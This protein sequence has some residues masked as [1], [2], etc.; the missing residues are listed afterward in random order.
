M[1]G[2]ASFLLSDFSTETLMRD[3]MK[4]KIRVE[5]GRYLFY[6]FTVLLK[7]SVMVDIFSPRRKITQRGKN[8]L[9]SPFSALYYLSSEI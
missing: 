3:E 6:S 9:P 2:E 7:D 5:E 8:Y 1:T 4:W